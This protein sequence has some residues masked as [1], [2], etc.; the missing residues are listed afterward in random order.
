MSIWAKGQKFIHPLKPKNQAV[1]CMFL[2]M[3]TEE[4]QILF[5]YVIFFFQ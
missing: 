5:V 2:Q 3:E 1:L 4:T